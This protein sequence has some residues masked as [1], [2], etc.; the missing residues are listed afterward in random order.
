MSPEVQAFASGFP[1]ML[2]H[3]GVSLLLLA[4]GSGVYALLSPNHEVRRIREGNPAAAVSLASVVLGLAMP[5]AAS[6]AAA[7][8]LLEIELWGF[9][10]SVLALL[11][12]S[13]L[14]FSLVGL[15]QRMHEGDVSAAVLLAAA[16][17]GAS[18]ILAAALAV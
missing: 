6:F 11:V 7:A 15:P 2:L 4:I 1:V 13:L 10:V 12:F 8:S 18:L 16:R 9:A 5:L 3:A 14:D 17:L